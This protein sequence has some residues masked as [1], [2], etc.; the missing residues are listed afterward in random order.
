MIEGKTYLFAY[1]SISLIKLEIQPIFLGR[2]NALEN[3]QVLIYSKQMQHAVS[4][5]E[6]MWDAV[7][8]IRV[9]QDIFPANLLIL[10]ERTNIKYLKGLK[11]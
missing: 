4:E 3:T 2:K 5:G 1:C 8:M 10:R 9:S 7:Y 6:D 11:N